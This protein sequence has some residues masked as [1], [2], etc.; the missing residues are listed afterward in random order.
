MGIITRAY[1][2]GLNDCIGCGKPLRKR[3]KK[4]YH[5]LKCLKMYQI[6]LEGVSNE[7]SISKA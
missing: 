2:F 7:L 1:S 4:R 5:S 6:K 3:D